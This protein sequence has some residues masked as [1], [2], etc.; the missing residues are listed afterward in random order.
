MAAK[1]ENPSFILNAVKN[2]TIEDRPIPT[3]KNPTDVLIRV[4]VTGICG[5]DVHYWEHGRIADFILTAPMVLGHE[6]AGTVVSTGPA[7]KTLTAG[8]RVAL[9]P[10]VPCRLCPFCKAGTYNLCTSM[11]FAATPPY[12]G[13]LAK[14]YVLPEDLC[15]RLPPHVSNDEGA[16]VEPLAVGVHVVR[17]AEVQPGNTVVVFGAG[18]VGLLIAAV[19]KAHGAVKVIMVDIVQPRLEFAKTYAATGTFNA[20]HSRDPKVNAAEIIKQFDL[21][22]GADV[23][24]DA[25]GAAPSINTAI[26]VVRTGGT[27]V[28][29]GMGA[30]EISFPIMAMCCKEITMKGSFRYGPGDYKLAVDL[31]AAGSVS[32]KE[33]ITSRFKFEDAEKAFEEQKKGKG[34][35]ILIDGPQD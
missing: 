6:S 23:A 31:L 13:T 32:V 28:Q 21:G 22:Y 8:D 2:V 12:D 35:K 1:H 26:H 25:S 18:P 24:I 11:R 34:I 7:C 16:L 3:L 29:A 17:Q 15:V 27:Y 5:S 30:D 10:G 9:E 14:Y 4:N 19:A 20:M 33:L